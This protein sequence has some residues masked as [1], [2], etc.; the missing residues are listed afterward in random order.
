LSLA[1]IGAMLVPTDK[2]I[3]DYFLPGGGG[4]YFIDLYGTHANTEANLPENLDDLFNRGNGV[5]TSFV[6]NLMLNS[7]IASVP[8]KFGTITQQGSGDFMG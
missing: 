1:D 8:S 6:N 2:A 5:L 7:F 3:K 4:A